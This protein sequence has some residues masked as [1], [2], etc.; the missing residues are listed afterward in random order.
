MIIATWNVSSGAIATR[1]TELRTEYDADIVAMQ[2]TAEPPSNSESC[3]WSGNL[4]HKGVSVSSKIPCTLAPVAGE[5]SPAVAVRFANSPMGPFNLLSVWAKP[6]PSYFADLSRTLD[7]YASFIRERPTVILGDF[8]MS[9]RLRQTG[10]KFSLL[11][12]RLNNDFGVHSAYHELTKEQFGMESMTTLYYRRGTAGCFHI[13]FVYVPSLW[14]PRL[15]AVT[16]P[17][18]IKFATSDHRPVVC[19]FI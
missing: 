1:L 18:Y 17:G 4:K 5:S 13:D 16:I 14:L 7:L 11:N 19:E 3:F 15:M 2:E 6:T 8:N 9:D 12:A 10:R